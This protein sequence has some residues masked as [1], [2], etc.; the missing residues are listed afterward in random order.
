M[1][2][3]VKSQD[4][5]MHPFWHDQN[6]FQGHNLKFL[7]GW[8]V[9]D[10]F[11]SMMVLF[12]TRPHEGFHGFAIVLST[13]FERFQVKPIVFVWIVPNH[14]QKRSP[15]RLPICFTG[16]LWPQCRTDPYSLVSI[17]WELPLCPFYRLGFST[18]NA[19]PNSLLYA[20]KKNRGEV[21]CW[22]KVEFS[23]FAT[24]PSGN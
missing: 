18:T 19:F 21:T 4:I 9:N 1:F 20:I 16:F 15:F 17:L 5:F 23:G 10:V 2:L 6:P 14:W 11:S 8:T 12:Q 7:F 13:T 3:V 24:V 22:A